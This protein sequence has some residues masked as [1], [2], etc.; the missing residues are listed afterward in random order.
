M[1]GPVLHAPNNHWT[2][3]QSSGRTLYLIVKCQSLFQSMNVLH[4]SQNKGPISQCILQCTALVSLISQSLLVCTDLPVSPNMS[5]SS[6]I[7]Q[8]QSA[9]IIVSYLASLSETCRRLI[10]S[11]KSIDSTLQKKSTRP[12][13]LFFV[14]EYTNDLLSIYQD[15]P[16]LENLYSSITSDLRFKYFESGIYF[17]NI[18]FGTSSDSINSYEKFTSILHNLLHSY[19]SHSIQAPEGDTTEIDQKNSNDDSI[20]LLNGPYLIEVI[21]LYLSYLEFHFKDIDCT[22][23]NSTSQIQNQNSGE[24]SEFSSAESIDDP[25]E[26]VPYLEFFIEKYRTSMLTTFRDPILTSP[27]DSL[28]GDYN[29]SSGFEI[30]E[31]TKHSVA[32]ASFQSPS[33]NR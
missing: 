14:R 1:W 5:E 15:S 23:I 19:I 4:E 3:N 21:Q 22:P 27:A 25:P 28:V 6:S 16:S 29:L 26:E 13:S 11:N 8:S 17:H 9:E 32:I 31:E 33:G 2:S 12:P 18:C 7:V 20:S 30:L 24:W 10:E